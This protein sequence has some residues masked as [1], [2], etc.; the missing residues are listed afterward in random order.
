MLSAARILL[1]I[2][3]AAVPLFAQAGTPGSPTAQLLAKNDIRAV[4]KYF[5]DVQRG[6]EKGN[7]SEI[8]LRNAFRPFYDLDENAANNLIAWAASDPG[9]YVA[10]LG[11]GIYYR[12]LGTSARGGKFMSDTPQSSVDRMTGYFVKAEKELRSSLALTKRPYLSIFHLL[13][14]STLV[15]DRTASQ[16]FLRKGNE[17]LPSN[18]LVRNRY[19]ISLTPRWGGSYEQ[20]EQFLSATRAE[21]LP[22][23][24]ALQIE[25]IAE[26]DKGKSLAEAGQ[27]EEARVHFRNALATGERVGG[28]FTEDFLSSSL[29]HTCAGR[30]RPS[31][32][33]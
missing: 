4:E 3:S 31:Y 27:H 6:F 1:F 24:V 11:L 9:S 23:E 20:L 14:I 7:L 22:Q 12:R 19:A 13:T 25:A 33:R 18:S 29:F 32:C 21:G 2:L 10:H 5:S 30:T 17:I 16:E 8:E 15:G 26:D 28:T